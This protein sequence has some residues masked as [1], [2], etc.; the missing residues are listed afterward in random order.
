MTTGTNAV[1]Y[2]MMLGT[3]QL[4][5]Q[6]GGIPG[7]DNVLA[8]MGQIKAADMA[9]TQMRWARQ[10]RSMNFYAGCTYQG[11]SQSQAALG[12]LY[13][14][15]NNSLSFNEIASKCDTVMGR[16]RQNRKSLM[17]QSRIP[18]YN[19]LATQYSRILSYCDTKGEISQE[20]SLGCEKSVNSGLAFGEIYLDRKNDLLNGEIAMKIWEG[21][22]VIY[23]PYCRD[24]WSFSDCR[25]IWTF[26]FGQKDQVIASYPDAADKIRTMGTSSNSNPVFMFLPEA[27]GVMQKN[28]LA[29]NRVWA[30][31][32]IEKTVWINQITSETLSY[33]PPESRNSIYLKEVKIPSTAWKLS[34]VIN[35]VVV[36]ERLALDGMTDCPFIAFT[37]DYDPE[38]QAQQ[39]RVR[40]MV[41]PLI[42][43]QWLIDRSIIKNHNMLESSV[44]TGWLIPHNTL[45]NDDTILEG[46]EGLNIPYEGDVPPQKILPTALPDSNFELI[47]NL[48]ASIE[49]ASAVKAPLGGTDEQSQSGIMSMIRQD[50]ADA[51]LQKR[52]DNWD[53]SLN[54]YGR[55]AME[56]I[57]KNWSEHKLGKI[58]QENPESC[59]PMK[60]VDLQDLFLT[61][62]DGLYTSVQKRAEFVNFVE[63]CAMLKVNI[64]VRLGLEKA[65]ING[66][67]ELIAALEEVEK[68]NQESQAQQMAIELS[69]KEAE[70]KKVNAQA[71]EQLNMAASH[72][73]RAGSYAG[74]ENERNAE[75]SRNESV[76][77]KNNVD[78]LV[79]L[80]PL[81]DKYGLDKISDLLLAL[82][83]TPILEH[84]DGKIE[85]TLQGPNIQPQGS[86]GLEL[87]SNETQPGAINGGAGRL[88]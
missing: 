1:N 27:V 57:A 46:S 21:R 36:E 42:D 62:E 22:A 32:P 80:Q 20:F 66:T 54:R 47:R 85:T 5:T 44:N 73:A 83:E 33:V 30:Q 9:T 34:V 8:L 67:E 76:S 40:S 69:L 86:G 77:I 15:D 35:N 65:P 51:P 79:K 52:F 48:R 55:L 71:L 87:Q 84:A 43:A 4:Y 88:P 78:S 10:S 31:V 70:I 37:W 64:P 7:P 11:Y 63:V 41:D 14:N 61:V 53:R 75:V 16:Q 74:L 2:P 23:D 12:N 81:I 24:I 56:L 28:T 68:S 59:K 29:V 26:Y 18:S 58:L 6:G 19:H 49:I 50:T 17:C 72:H 38:I 82:K 25:Y 3:S 60:Q 13:S 45:V 39:F